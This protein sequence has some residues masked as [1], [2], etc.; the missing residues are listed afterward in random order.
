MLYGSEIAMVE[1]QKGGYLELAG[2]RVPEASD[3]ERLKS[4]CSDKTMMVSC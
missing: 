1:G 3:A 4:C 2:G